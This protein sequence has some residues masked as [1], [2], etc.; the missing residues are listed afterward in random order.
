MSNFTVNRKTICS[1]YKHVGEK[2]LLKCQRFQSKSV[3]GSNRSIGMY[4]HL[5]WFYR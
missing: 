1:E 3:K 2:Q 4:L 5:Q